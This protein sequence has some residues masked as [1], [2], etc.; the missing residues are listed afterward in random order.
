MMNRWWAG[1]LLSLLAASVPSGCDLDGAAEDSV[2]VK[3]DDLVL[4]VDITGA[5]SAV[6]SDAL[7]PPMIPQTWNFKITHMA[8][9]GKEIKEGE[10]ALGF[11]TSDMLRQLDEK[12]NELDAA[13]KELEKT[14]LAMKM[15]RRG[16]E[17]A[18]AE[19]AAELRKAEL[20]A[21]SP[22][23]LTGAIELRSAV[24]DLELRRKTV[25]H[26][27]AKAEHTRRRDDADLAALR[28]RKNRAAQRVSE[29]EGQ[30]ARM[31]IKAPR[32]GT[33]IYIPNWRGDKMKV[34]DGTWRGRKV[35][36]IA[37]LDRM[38]AKG[39]VDEVDASK[40]EVGQR[41]TLRLD[42]H[43]DKEI[44]GEVSSIADTVQRKSWDTPLKV[45]RLE[46]K[47]E[48]TDPREMRPG[49]RF[50]GRVETGRV[51]DVLLVPTDAVFVSET[52]P[53]AYRLSGDEYQ[54]VS[55]EVGQRNQ[56][57][58]EVKSGLSLGDRVARTN[59]SKGAG[60]GG[61]GK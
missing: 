46:I 32:A 28:D 42:A 30:I 47:L 10:V 7:G 17:L 35:L 31:S 50:R 57:Y 6:D 21:E 45:V 24:L 22:A 26:L 60:S 33:V 19:A 43:P 27:Q 34:G 23:E 48:H 1:M 12:K 55:I 54:A 58:V 16:D 52:G 61:G 18:F 38:M 44:V 20:K 36:E 25:A 51:K 59:P 39:E 5:L 29:I 56:K 14:R 40:I 2:V 8:P 37:S 3:R 4:G 53:V 11:D 13:T 41:V 15:A 49:M 9:E